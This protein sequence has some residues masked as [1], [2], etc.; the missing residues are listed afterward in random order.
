MIK[1]KPMVNR[2]PGLKLRTLRVR[3]REFLGENE[4]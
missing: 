2:T 4:T 1:E 3:G